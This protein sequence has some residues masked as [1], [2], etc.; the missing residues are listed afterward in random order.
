MDYDE[1]Q[2]LA[3]ISYK[4]EDE[5]WAKWLQH[6]LEHYKLPTSV[7]KINPSLPRAAR[8]VFKDTTDLAGGVLEKAIKEA[9]QSSKYLIVICSPR[10]AKS[11]WVCKEVQ[12]FIDSGREENIIPFIIDGEPNTSDIANECFP[13]N[14][15]NLSGT[16]EL[17]GINI[18]EMGRNAAAIKVVARMFCLH[19]DTLWR[20]WERE[21]RIKRIQQFSLLLL[22]LFA[23]LVIALW[24]WNKN[25]ELE[26]K[27]THIERQNIE[28][29][30]DLTEI[31]LRQGKP[32]MSIQ[33]IMRYKD[34]IYKL[35][36][37]SQE[38]YIKIAQ[39]CVDSLSI[40]PIYLTSVGDTLSRKTESVYDVLKESTLKFRFDKDEL[41]RD[42]YYFVIE[43]SK[44][45]YAG[46]TKSVITNK[47]KTSLAMF[48]Y[49]REDCIRIHSLSDGAMTDSIP[50]DGYTLS[51]TYPMSL[52]NDGKRLI[53]YN[54]QKTFEKVF[55]VD[56]NNNSVDL[57]VDSQDVWW[58]DMLVC[59]ADFSNDSKLF[60]LEVNNCISLYE[61][62]TR[63]IIKKLY[64][65]KV[66]DVYWN[67][68][69]DLCISSGGL[70]YTWA[71]R[72]NGLIEIYNTGTLV[73]N[74][75]ISANNRYF[76][77]VCADG[78]LYVWDGKTD[79]CIWQKSLWGDEFSRPDDVEFSR[80]NKSIWVIDAYG[81][82]RGVDLS[83]G[84]LLKMD[85]RGYDFSNATNFNVGSSYLLFTYD[86]K[87]CITYESWCSKYRIFDVKTGNFLSSIYSE[88]GLNSIFYDPLTG[89][90][91][92]DGKI[93]DLKNGKA[94]KPGYTNALSKNAER[95][96]F[97]KFMPDNSITNSNELNYNVSA[98]KILIK[99]NRIIEAL[100]NGRVKIMPINSPCNLDSIVRINNNLLEG[101]YSANPVF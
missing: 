100:T 8:P 54:G 50:C 79:K 59:R 61:S 3:F 88:N 83:K 48:D 16:R 74:V 20:R 44:C 38:R 21:Q 23:S 91:A 26:E 78:T 92:V 17:L 52:S 67:D 99:Q 75:A 36:N 51:S 12:E 68:Y 87:Y 95:M 66:D 72:N 55:F 29:D 98:R 18:N 60:F 64:F 19:F 6:K 69:G 82:L 31:Y 35:D 41:Y 77:V 1:Y 81:E 34:N 4:R 39:E 2:Y 73:R 33:L 7:R 47:N 96:S 80:D 9:L 65:E 13:Q 46:A 76:G 89:F 90:I 27:N 49:D 14:L 37:I 5:A 40:H 42:S 43:A 10:A 71:I 97:Y 45:E 62:N 101:K 11:L 22:I 24:M 56:F 57:L 32:E 86:N 93:Y 15:R 25:I 94:L 63:R 30:V 58:L 70:L 84:K 28:K 85:E 53:Y